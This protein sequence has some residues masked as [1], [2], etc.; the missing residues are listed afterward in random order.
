VEGLAASGR[1]KNASEVLREG[2]RLMEHRENETTARLLALRAQV[3]V[4]LEDMASG[5]FTEFAS[6]GAISA[7]LQALADRITSAV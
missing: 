6:P 2:L 7:H 5:H 1:Y 4:G 3:Q